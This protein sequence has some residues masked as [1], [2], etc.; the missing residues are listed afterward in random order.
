MAVEA[1]HLNFS[2]PQLL[3]NGLVFITFSYFS[4]SYSSVFRVFCLDLPKL[5]NVQRNDERHWR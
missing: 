2:P 4:S 5:L 1:R 3:N